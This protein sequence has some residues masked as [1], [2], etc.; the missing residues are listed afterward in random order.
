M[1]ELAP[2]DRP[3]EKLARVGAAALGDNELLAAVLGHGSAS[4]GALTLANAVLAAVGG[5]V[6]LTRVGH[7]DLC[8]LPAVGAARASQMLAAIELGRRTLFIR[9]PARER[10]ASPRE[11]AAFLLP[12]FGARNVEQSGVV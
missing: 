8:A 2:H 5:L 3:R 10:F 7:D 9:S 11:M 6:G 12:Q 4:Y 1:K